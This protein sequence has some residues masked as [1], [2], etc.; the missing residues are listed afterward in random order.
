M[1]EWVDGRSR[2]TATL[3]NSVD[4]DD[5]ELLDVDLILHQH[6]GRRFSSDHHSNDRF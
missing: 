2:P 5:L 4:I 6:F 1:I 3:T